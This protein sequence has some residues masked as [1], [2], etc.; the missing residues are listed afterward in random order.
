[1]VAWRYDEQWPLVLG[2]NRD[3]WLDR[4]TTA[5]TVLQP[6]DPRI[7]GGRDERA[8][9]TW[10]AVNEYGVVCGLT[11]RPMP[12]GPDPTKRSRGRLPLVAAGTRTAE[13]AAE[14]LAG[15]V[16]LGSY[17][18]AWLLVGDRQSLH[19]L[20]VEPGESTEPQRLAPGLHVLENAALDVPSVKV[21]HVRAAVT[22]AEHSGVPLWNSL[23]ALLRDHTVSNGSTDVP[24]FPDGRER[25]MASLAP[26]VHADGY[27]TRSSAMVRLS[28]D[29]AELPELLVA[30]GPPCEVPFVDARHLWSKSST[31]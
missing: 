30:D 19:Y 17:N 6:E 21:D 12:D 8:S 2:A 16:A 14:A 25:L 15:E 23:P 27:G 7:L 3:E 4:P 31:S 28:E 11:N 24:R 5:I 20:A 13:E 10:M 22:G 26:C 18:P 9:G 1:V 29:P